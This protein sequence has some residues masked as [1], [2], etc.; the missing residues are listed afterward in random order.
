MEMKFYEHALEKVRSGD[1]R[2]LE[3]LLNTLE[4]DIRLQYER[5]Y[6]LR[7]KKYKEFADD[8]VQLKK[9]VVKATY[10]YNEIAFFLN[11]IYD[12]PVYSPQKIVGL[13]RGIER[14]QEKPQNGSNKAIIDAIGNVFAD[15]KIVYNP[16]TNVRNLVF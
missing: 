1:K 14:A 16:R 2:Y 12:K 5:N 15:V 8:F 7:F 6:D 4:Q 3:A 10:S 9:P 13:I 11:L